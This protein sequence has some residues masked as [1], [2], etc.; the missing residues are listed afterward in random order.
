M[1]KESIYEKSKRLAIA[2]NPNGTPQQIKNSTKHYF[3]HFFKLRN[4]IRSISRDEKGKLI[5]KRY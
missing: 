4:N 3:A 5:L 1:K 2:D